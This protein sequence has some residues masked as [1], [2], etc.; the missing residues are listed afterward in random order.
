MRD[1][2]VYEIEKVGKYTVK[3]VQDTD[4]LNPRVHWDNIGTMVCFHRRYNLGDKHNM[5][6]DEAQEFI[7]R[8]D[9]YSLPLF[10]YDHSGIT[11]STAPFSCSW[12]SGQVGFIYMDRET[13]LK[14][15]GGKRVNKKR[16]YDCLRAEVEEYDNYLT[17]DVYGYKVVE[18]ESG[19]VID[20][21]WGYF[22]DS[23]YALSEG[24]AHAKSNIRHD[25]KEHLKRLRTWI[26]NRVPL[27]KREPLH[28]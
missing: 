12:D 11:M 26:L 5:D 24:V 28:I 15:F 9:I 8:K 25:I 10:L 13:Y 14:E 7:K 27:E 1:E 2:Y 20:S 23:K 18:D 16:L 3:V 17:G 21:C 22:G 6:I 4:P 19:D